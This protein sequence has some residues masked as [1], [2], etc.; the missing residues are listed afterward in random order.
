[1]AQHEPQGSS[2]PPAQAMVLWDIHRSLSELEVSWDNKLLRVMQ[3]ELTLCSPF[4]LL[5]CIPGRG[6]L[7]QQPHVMW[8]GL[9]VPRCM[10]TISTCAG[11]ALID[12]W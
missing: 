12:F 7:A 6:E 9:P 11:F 4:C 5:V 3:E 2:L 10:S 8:L 1:M